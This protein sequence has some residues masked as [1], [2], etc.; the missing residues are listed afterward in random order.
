MKGLVECMKV[1]L[2]LRG[3][4]V[5][6]C[7]LPVVQQYGPDPK[8]FLDIWYLVTNMAG[9]AMKAELLYHERK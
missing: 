5:R 1:D 2:T 4:R 8:K 9:F 6:Y 7:G 3:L